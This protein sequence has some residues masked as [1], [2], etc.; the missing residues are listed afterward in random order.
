MKL[1]ENTL[2]ILLADDDPDDRS[3]FEKALKEIP[4]DT[5]LVSV[6]NGEELM[7]YL[8]KNLHNL[9]DAIFLDLSMPRKT[10]YECLLE[11][12]ENQDLKNIHVV[13]FS[14]SFTGGHIDLEKTLINTLSNMGAKDYIRKPGDFEKLKQVIHQSLIRLIEKENLSDIK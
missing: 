7:I 11:I 12:Q 13:M 2:N 5:H 14:T 4:L 9:P 8:A 6:N 3:F 1:K 10:G